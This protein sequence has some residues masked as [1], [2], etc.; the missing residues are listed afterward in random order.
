M[1][2]FVCVCVCVCVCVDGWVGGVCGVYAVFVCVG[3]G[4]VCVVC[5]PCLCVCVCVRGVCA[6]GVCT[7]CVCVCC[8]HAVFVFVCVEGC[9]RRVW[10]V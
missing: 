10:Y 5:T 8:V 2:V 1:F 9:A 6:E 4:R 3:E 7:T